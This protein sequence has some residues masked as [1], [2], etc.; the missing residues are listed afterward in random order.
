ML[1]YLIK[2]VQRIC[3]YPLL[4][5]ELIKHTP[6]DGKFQATIE[7]L[8]ATKH[9]IEEVVT[10]I[11]EG[12]RIAESMQKIVEIQTCIEGTKLDLVTFTRRFI[13]QGNLQ[14]YDI[15][16]PIHVILF[17]DLL[18]LTRQKTN[19]TGKLSYEI[20]S[21]M[22]LEE[23]KL[24]TVADTEEFQHAFELNIPSLNKTYRLCASNEREKEG[25]LKDLKIA[26]KEIQKRQYEMK[27]GATQ[28]SSM[29]L[30]PGTV[31]TP[32]VNNSVQSQSPIAPISAERATPVPIST[33]AS[34]TPR[35][36]SATNT[37]SSPNLSNSL[38]VVPPS[39]PTNQKTLTN[40]AS[41]SASASASVP[42]PQTPVAIGSVNSTTSSLSSSRVETSTIA[43]NKF[44]KVDSKTLDDLQKD[45]QAEFS[46]MFSAFGMTE[47]ETAPKIP[48]NSSLSDSFSQ[49][50]YDL[51]HIVDNL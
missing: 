49:L 21:K 20:K 29:Q 37:S 36:A 7:L 9:Q 27:F 40:S 43:E 50:E 15:H 10:Y 45:I 33:T 48:N 13:R 39:N 26:I 12:R 41:A 31:P 46:D 14:H 24:I 3:K 34:S 42:K 38:K 51:D 2:P 30:A 18:L 25:W 32:V 5:N 47:K 11:N 8:T 23:A 17:N 16:E 6:T 44:T 22:D 28:R 4:F 35:A 1:S 19:K